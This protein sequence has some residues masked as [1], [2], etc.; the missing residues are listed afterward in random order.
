MEIV[1][2][3][4]RERNAR[5][6]SGDAEMIVTLD[7]GPRILFFGPAEGAN[8][9]YT[10][11]EDEGRQGG[12][13][14]R[15][16][17][18][19][20]LW[21]A[22]EEKARTMQPD[23]ASVDYR[24]EA[25]THVF[26]TVPDLNHISKE[27]R[28]TTMGDERFRVEHWVKNHGPYPVE[29]AAWG[30][31]QMLPGTV[32]FPQSPFA[33]HTEKLLPTRPL[34]MWAYTRLGDPRWTWGNEVVRLQH[35]PMRGPQKIGVFIEQGYAAYEGQGCVFMKRWHSPDGNY[36]DY[37]CNFETF[38]NEVMI[39]IETLG[40]MVTLGTDSST[41]HVEEWRLFP[42]ESLPREDGACAQKLAL[43]AA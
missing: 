11:P 6:V 33:P 35:D 38:T 16:Y 17:G 8:L 37:G 10:I 32:F 12:D 3:L 22:P 40:P 18:G 23:N 1:P 24:V 9:L 43:L 2:F 7:V 19:H 25:A 36:A 41:N 27:I 39:E 26:K 31:T 5:I 13:D 28:I 21:I 14:Y 34:V 15:F 20:R 30:P 29:L 4:G 42:D